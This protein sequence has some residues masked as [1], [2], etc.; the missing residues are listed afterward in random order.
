MTAK[1]IDSILPDLSN[2]SLQG[3]YRFDEGTYEPQ[4]DVCACGHKIHNV[5]SVYNPASGFRF[6]SG[7]CC[8]HKNELLSLGDIAKAKEEIGSKKKEYIKK[9]DRK[10]CK[11]EG[12]GKFISK[13]DDSE[14]CNKCIKKKKKLEAR[15]IQNIAYVGKWLVHV[16]VLRERR[17][18]IL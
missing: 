6:S 8:C 17:M 1:Q 4:G 5:I 12:C 14:L 18:R 9:R 13:K 16:G 3:I 10:E 2:V 15:E 7:D 11:G